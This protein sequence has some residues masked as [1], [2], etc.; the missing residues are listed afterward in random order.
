MHS[1]Y[2]QV[3][4]ILSGLTK[5]SL[6]VIESNTCIA[7]IRIAVKSTKCSNTFFLDFSLR[8]FFRIVLKQDSELTCQPVSETGLL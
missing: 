6:Q 1:K 7:E 8:H 4:P 2:L 5:V 3:Q